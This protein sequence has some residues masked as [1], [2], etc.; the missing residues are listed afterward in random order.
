MYTGR[1]SRE[2]RSSVTGRLLKVIG[3]L[4]LSTAQFIPA[5]HYT[6]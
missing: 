5:R 3:K 1:F 6:V 4:S 2:L